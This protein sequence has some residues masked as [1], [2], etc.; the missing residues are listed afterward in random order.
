MCHP[1]DSGFFHK[2]EEIAMKRKM[3]GI[4][5]TA[6]ALTF[7]GFGMPATA[8]DRA[9][10]TVNLIS[11]PFGT[12]S[13]VISSALEQISKKHAWLRIVSSESPGFVYNIKKLAGEP[14]LQKTTIMGSGPVVIALAERGEKPFDKKYPGVKVLANYN[15][16]AVWLATLN[17]NIKTVNDLVGKKIALGRAPQINWAVEPRGV[18]N[19]GYG[20]PA[21][22]I[23]IQY[24][25][26]KEAVAAL[27][28]GTVDAAVVG[29]YFDPEKGKIALSPQTMEFVASGRKIGYLGWT[30]DAVKKTAA[31]GIPISPYTLPAKSFDGLNEALPIFVDNVAWVAS[32][33][34]PEDLA[35]EIT[36]LIIDNVDK[37]AEY[38]AIGK[39]MSRGALAFGW[40]QKDIHP[41]ALRAYKEAGL[42]K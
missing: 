30:A 36:K 33:N 21:D 5:I 20:I 18:I 35:Y 15:L 28:D 32:P 16:V 4:G 14:A 24:A 12:G 26:P 9:P 3:L 13:Y 17:P 25:G 34:F 23:N 38:S 29:G 22:K 41:G 7:A 42:L 31:Q 2:R 19:I 40:P 8:A 1:D 11:A 39:L 6:A 37:F 27:L 10:V